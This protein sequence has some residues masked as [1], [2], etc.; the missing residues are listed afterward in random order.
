MA[1]QILEKNNLS[2]S[3]EPTAD[4]ITSAQAAVTALAPKVHAKRAALEV[5]SA[6][7][8][9]ARVSSAQQAAILAEATKQFAAG[10]KQLATWWTGVLTGRS[11]RPQTPDVKAV[12]A[13]LV[14]NGI[15]TPQDVQ[16]IFA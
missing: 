3:I 7:D 10:A 1:W 2:V 9:L 13:L 6:K 15:L 4:Q 12:A 14:A 11:V 8:F 16:T 5:V